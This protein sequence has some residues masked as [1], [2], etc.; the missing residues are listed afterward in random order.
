MPLMSTTHVDY[1]TATAGSRPSPSTVGVWES[2]SGPQA[3][4]QAARGTPPKTGSQTQFLM[5]L[6]C[7]FD[8]KCTMSCVSQL[9][10]LMNIK[11]ILFSTSFCLVTPDKTFISVNKSL[12]NGHHRPILD[13]KRNAFRFFPIP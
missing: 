13:F 6:L 10:E 11:S 9:E 12:V 5:L 4:Q 3:R 8:F 1:H 7:L 2:N